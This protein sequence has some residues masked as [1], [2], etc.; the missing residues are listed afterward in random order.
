[1]F[2]SVKCQISS[3]K[4]ANYPQ[5]TPFWPR[6]STFWQR[7]LGGLKKMKKNFEEWVCRFWYE[8]CFTP[9]PHFGTAF[10]Y[11]K[12][13]QQTLCQSVM[14]TIRS[15]SKRGTFRNTGA[16]WIRA[17]YRHKVRN[18]GKS[19]TRSHIVLNLIIYYTINSTMYITVLCGT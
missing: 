4:I 18:K 19:S 9:S 7:F 3:G 16:K 1:M 11:G 17:K 14:F 2:G 8:N 12:A 10:A 13:L 6:F 5:N 15:I